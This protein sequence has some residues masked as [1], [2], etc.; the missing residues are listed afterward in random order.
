[1]RFFEQKTGNVDA[2]YD[3]IRLA[4]PSRTVTA[5]FNLLDA[6]EKARL[7]LNVAEAMWSMKSSSG[8][9]PISDACIQT[10]KLASAANSTR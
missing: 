6:G 3:R 10:M 1:M 4:A 9:S 8:S 5:L 7:Y 2:F